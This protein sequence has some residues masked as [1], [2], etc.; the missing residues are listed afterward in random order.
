MNVDRHGWPMRTL[1]QPWIGLIALLVVLLWRALAHGV[2]V[3]ERI[4]LGESAQ[5]VFGFCVGILGLLLVWRGLRE[6]ELPASVMG[7]LGG[8]FLWLGWFEHAFE[9][10][11]RSM[12]IPPL[13]HEGRYALPPNLV[14]LE[15]TGFILVTL[16]VL[17][18]FNADTGCRAFMWCRRVLRIAVGSPSRGLRKSYSRLVALEYVCV[19]WFMYIAII[20]LLDPRIAGK[21]SLVTQVAFWGLLLWSLYLVSLCARRVSQP[22][23]GLRYAVGAGGIVWL[24]VELGAQLKYWVEIWIKPLQMPIPNV[25]FLLMFLALLSL[26]SVHQERGQRRESAVGESAV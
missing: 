19:S 26:L 20:L 1:G 2:V 23:M 7:F 11:A 9:W 15:A 3:L 21:D 24:T 10:L 18:A 12:A 17:F 16:M 22:G 13:M 14:L 5:L 25:L 8:A 6:D 4:W